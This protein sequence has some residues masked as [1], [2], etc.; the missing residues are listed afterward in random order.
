M[1]DSSLLGPLRIL[2]GE[3]SEYCTGSPGCIVINALTGC[4][5]L[6]LASYPIIDEGGCN[7]RHRIRSTSGGRSI[8]VRK[9]V[10]SNFLSLRFTVHGF[11]GVVV[12]QMRSIGNGLGYTK[13]GG[14]AVLF[15][16]IYIYIDIATSIQQTAL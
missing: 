12:D 8:P 1:A 10:P 16:C 15:L 13:G 6:L 7:T 9:S 11:P 5:A 4:P 3:A 2:P 14:A